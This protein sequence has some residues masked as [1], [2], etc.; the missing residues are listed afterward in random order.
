MTQ[1][2]KRVYD[3]YEAALSSASRHSRRIEE[4]DDAVDSETLKRQRRI[5]GHFFE[6]P[7][8]CHNIGLVIKTTEDEIRRLDRSVRFEEDRAAGLQ[9]EIDRLSQVC[10]YS[11]RLL[12]SNC[13]P[14]FHRLIIFIS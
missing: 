12:A 11:I 3:G 6:V 14:N 1:R 9:H 4:N 13:L 10:C 5:E 8:L 7:V 2:E